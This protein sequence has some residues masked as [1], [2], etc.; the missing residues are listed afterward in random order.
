MEVKEIIQSRL[1]A[2][3]KLATLSKEELITLARTPEEFDKFISGYALSMNKLYVC[4]AYRYNDIIRMMI[5]EN[6][7]R[8]EGNEEL[9]NNVYHVLGHLDSFAKE[10]AEDRYEFACQFQ[11]I[12]EHEL[13]L[14]RFDSTLED[15]DKN[16]AGI[17][18]KMKE[19][20]FDDI[21]TDNNYL[22]TVRFLGRFYAGYMSNTYMLPSIQ[23]T[24]S[25]VDRDDFE[26]K[27]EYKKFK[28]SATKTMYKFDKS[29][30]KVRKERAKALTIGSHGYKW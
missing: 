28:R 19:L 10:S 21:K 8:L 13:G 18:R 20:D 26:T 17:F 11:A 30:A 4:Y 5:N 27:D 25:H 9:S 22:A 2:R 23:Q 14:D 15:F 3:E 12:E 16:A 1:D 24:L 6:M 7:D 29:L